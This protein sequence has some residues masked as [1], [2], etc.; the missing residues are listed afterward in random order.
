MG[1]LKRTIK[2]VINILNPKQSDDRLKKLSEETDILQKQTEDYLREATMNGET[3]WF[4]QKK[5][6]NHMDIGG[7]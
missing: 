4:L 1:F 2:I 5:K 7:V 6:I 3:N